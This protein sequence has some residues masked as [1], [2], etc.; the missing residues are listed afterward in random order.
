M[1]S[2]A[3]RSGVTA[4]AS[5]AAR[6]PGRKPSRASSALVP[7]ATSSMPSLAAVRHEYVEQLGLAVEAAVRPVGGVPAAGSSRRSPASGA[8]RRARGR[9]RPPGRA[10]WRG[11]TG[12]PRSPRPR[13]SA[14][15]A[16]TAA[17]SR[18]AESAPPEKATTTEPRSRSRCVEV[19]QLLVE[20]HRAPCRGRARIRTAAQAAPKPL[21]MPTT[22]TPGL[23]EAIIPSSAVTPAKPGAVA[24]AGRHR[25]HRRRGQAGDDA[26]QRAL[27]AGDHQ[28]HVGGRD[29]VLLLEHPVQAGD[30][31]VGDHRPPRGRTP[32]ARPRPRGPPAGRWCRR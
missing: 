31:D 9:T 27:H 23:Q 30:A 8:G 24:G 25:D 6:M 22:V 11:A 13:A 15:S 5:A 21:S 12:S 4:P 10:R 20:G 1:V 14:P 2:P 18:N 17:A 3:S 16:R 29:P 19:G 26:G 7:V 32:R 28:H